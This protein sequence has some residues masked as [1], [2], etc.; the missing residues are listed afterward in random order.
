MKRIWLIARQEY[1]K[2]VTRRGFLISVM[3]FPIWI[4]LVAFLP[5]TLDRATPSRTFTVIDRAGGYETAIADDIARNDTA[6]TLAALSE[7]ARAN[8]DMAGLHAGAP[9]IAEVARG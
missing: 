6:S 8:A 1:I 3:L 9:G 2:Y 7:Y 4:G 5:G